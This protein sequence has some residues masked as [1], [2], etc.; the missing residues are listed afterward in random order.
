MLRGAPRGM[1]VFYEAVILYRSTNRF[2][3][4]LFNEYQGIYYDFYYVPPQQ[5]T[6]SPVGDLL[7]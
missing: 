3:R 6:I 7:L 4:A 5:K 1:G 2:A